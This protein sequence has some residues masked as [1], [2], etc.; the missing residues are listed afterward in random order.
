MAFPSPRSGCPQAGVVEA[1]YGVT[2]DNDLDVAPGEITGLDPARAD[3]V[4]VLN[5]KLQALGKQ[6]RLGFTYQD[7]VFTG[8]LDVARKP[9]RVAAATVTFFR[10]DREDTFLAP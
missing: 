7:T 9:S 1:L 2:A 3:D 4:A 10:V 8:T 5:N 6:V